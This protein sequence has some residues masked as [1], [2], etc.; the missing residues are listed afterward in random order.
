MR[1]Y[2]PEPGLTHVPSAP[3]TT[4]ATVDAM[5]AWTVTPVRVTGLNPLIVALTEYVPG[6]TCGTE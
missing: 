2:E 4:I 3:P 6:W 5:H 1:G